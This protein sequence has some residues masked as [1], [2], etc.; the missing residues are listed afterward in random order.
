MLCSA[1][2][3]RASLRTSSCRELSISSCS[4]PGPFF[5][6]EHQQHQGHRRQPSPALPGKNL[7][8]L[9]SALVCSL[10]GVPTHWEKPPPPNLPA[11]GDALYRS[12][13]ARTPNGRQLQGPGNRKGK[14]MSLTGTTATCTGHQPRQAHRP[15]AKHEVHTNRCSDTHQAATEELLTP[16]HQKQAGAE[17]DA[18]VQLH[19]F[20]PP[21]SQGS[22]RNHIPGQNFPATVMKAIPFWCREPGWKGWLPAVLRSPLSSLPG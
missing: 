10:A 16:D 20:L 22:G 2:C 6:Q 21:T 14:V 9:Q 8:P 5:P 15:E 3:F 17:Y 12:S 7:L 4:C 11:P 13:V 18:A 1:R 19:S